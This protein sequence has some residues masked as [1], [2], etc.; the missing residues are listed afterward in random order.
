M[1]SNRL[2][3][4]NISTH[5]SQRTILERRRPARFISLSATTPSQLIQLL[6]LIDNFWTISRD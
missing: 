3:N 6:F 1:V 4:G 5:P 2:V